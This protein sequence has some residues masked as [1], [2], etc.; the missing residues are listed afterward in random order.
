MALT[1][2]AAAAALLGALVVLAFRNWA[3]L[4]AV[5]ALLLAGILADLML[6]ASVRRAPHHPVR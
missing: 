6:A 2:R 5:N 1:G 4:A 3:A